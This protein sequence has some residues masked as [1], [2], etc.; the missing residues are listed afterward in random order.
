MSIRA[1]GMGVGWAPVRV[2]DQGTEWP[3]LPPAEGHLNFGIS[4][5]VTASRLKTGGTQNIQHN[6]SLLCMLRGK[7]TW[8]GTH[9]K[10]TSDDPS[11]YLTRMLQGQAGQSNMYT[12]EQLLQRAQW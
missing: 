5:R 10:I 1:W 3:A 4:I 6:S 8:H 2:R 12:G 11:V 7:W 9:M